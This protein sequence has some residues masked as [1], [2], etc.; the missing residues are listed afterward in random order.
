MSTGFEAITAQVKLVIWDLDETFWQGTL[1][2]GGITPIPAHAEMIKTLA[3]R[4]I[5]SSICSKNDFDTAKAELERLGV[6]DYIVFPH[7]DW[8]PK[9]Q[10]IK[11]M[12]SAM[13]LR[14][15]NVVF[16]DD[17]HMNLEEAAF[18]NEGLMCVDATQPLAGLLDLPQM[19]G[20]DD[21]AHSRLAQYKMLE[22]K[23]AAQAEGAL[24]N[25]AFL[26]QSQI[27]VE[28]LTDLEPHMDRVLELIN[29]T[30]QLN[31]T[32]NRVETPEARAE[33][34]ALLATSGVHAGLVR[35]TDRY[36]D[37]GI[38][39][40][41]AARVKYSGTTV[42]HFCFSCRTLNMGVEQF[43]WQRIGAPEFDFKGPVA[44][45]LDAGAEVDWI[46]EASS[47]DQVFSE[48]DDRTLCL[49]GGCDL[50]QVSFY[51]GT[52][53]HEFVNK[54]DRGYLVRYDDP[55]FFLNPRKPLKH[56]QTLKKFP[57]WSWQD[58]EDLDVAL[59]DSDVVLLSLY[60]AVPGDTFFTFGGKEWGGEYLVK[61]PPRT[62]KKFIKSDQALWFAKS[63]YHRRYTL[64]ESLEL[65]RRSMERAMSLVK[66]DAQVF[67]LTAATKTGMQAERTGEMRA[68]YN[69]MCKAFC[70]GHA[71]AHLVDL[72]EVLLE[73]DFQDSDHYTRA[74]YFKIAKCVNDYMADQS[75]AAADVAAE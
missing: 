43:V 1:S 17:N 41:F 4:G 75:G 53:R 69:A 30:N 38:V 66:P 65:T 9:G 48:Q 14:A 24:D 57:T 18:F 67:V 70:A 32:K 34:D 62:L 2:E 3:D 51:C 8:T 25:M 26:R 73:E 19:K 13:G 22:T 50:L 16:L 63:F 46:A 61:V 15:P 28:I 74:G 6:W 7:I 42:H 52:N 45:Q 56:D 35:V 59:A 33:L 37:Y 23:Q 10:A 64:E 39:G 60:Y 29:R 40:F 27:R 31:F 68:A 72:D 36:G 47:S 44:S 49:V 5:M 12:L 11:T 55:G 71:Q 54:E 58:M 21:R 20:K